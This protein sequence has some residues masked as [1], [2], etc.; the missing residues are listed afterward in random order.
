MRFVPLSCLG[1]L[2]VLTAHSLVDFSM[3]IPGLAVL[4][5]SILGA[6]AAI[7][8]ESLGAGDRKRASV[9]AGGGGRARAWAESA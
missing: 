1:I 3:Q 8:L 7:S 5:G 2:A 9:V 4:V 6:G